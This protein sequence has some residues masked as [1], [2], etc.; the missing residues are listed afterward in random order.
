MFFYRLGITLFCLVLMCSAGVNASGI[1]ISLDPLSSAEQEWLKQHRPVSIGFDANFPPYS[2]IGE[3]GQLS[4]FAVDVLDLLE[5]RSGLRFERRIYQDWSSLYE[6]A[7]SHKIDTVATMV[8]RPER[9][10]WFRFSHPYIHKSLVIIGNSKRNDIRFRDDIDGKSIALVKGYQYESQILNE[11][12]GVK[13][14]RVDTMLDALNSVSVGQADAAITFLGAGHFYRSKYLMNDLAYLA[15]YDKNSANESYAVRADWPELAGLIDKVLASIT[16]AEMQALRKRWLPV[17]YMENLVEIEFTEAER[18]WLQKHDRVRVGIDPEFAPF[19]YLENGQYSGMASDYLELLSQR[20]NLRMEVVEGLSWAEVIDSAKQGKIDVL[21]AVGL[22]QERL[23]YLNYTDP[24]LRFHR[25]IVTREQ[26]PFIAGLND[27]RSLRVAVQANSSHQGYLQENSDIKPIVYPSLQASLMAVS[28]GEVDAFVGNVASS[29]YWIRKLNLNNLKIAAPVSNDMQSL[30]FAVSKQSPE[31]VSILQ[32]GLDS[33]GPHQRKLISEKWLSVE[34]EVERD[35]RLL[36][37]IIVGFSIALLLVLLW[38]YLLKRKVQQRTSELSYAANYDHLTGLANR[39][40]IL[41]RL[42]QW[43]IQADR[44]NTKIA[45]LSIDIDDFKKINDALGHS[46]GDLILKE[47]SERLR[48]V[49]GDEQSIGRVGGDQFLVVQRGVR[50]AADSARLAEQLIVANKRAFGRERNSVSLRSSMGIAL[51]PS[52][53]R[54]A[55]SLLKQ[56]DTATHHAKEKLPG[57][58]TFFTGQLIEKVSRKLELERHI[59]QA[60][61][62]GEFEVFFQPK[63]ETRSREIVSFEAL[64]RWNC[65]ALGAVSPVEFIPL[66]EQTG[67]IESIGYFVLDKAMQALADWKQQFGKPYSMAVNLSPLQFQ[68]DDLVPSI[69]SLLLR[70]GVSATELEFEITEGVLLSEYPGVE[71]KLNALERLGAKLAMDDFGKGYSSLSYLRK[72]RFDTLK[73]DREFISDLSLELADRKLVAATIVMAHELGL[74]VVAEGVE[75]QAQCDIL[76]HQGCDLLQGWLFS[77]AL[78]FDGITKLLT[79]Q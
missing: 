19:E 60:L 75:T 2:F 77:K 37:Y 25:V 57:R 64:L 6:D 49:V 48:T 24:Y 31:L 30:H 58:Y 39:F 8:N 67:L 73:I 38:N 69:E 68:A 34:Y 21:P 72:Y 76:A 20:L 40:L 11:F 7:K 51:F 32:K 14:V 35:Y 4:G 47:F 15:V 28:G 61:D 53:S 55:E 44:E 46:Q 33:I 54:T 71:D 63:V 3:D 70:H 16:E 17:E 29:T 52:D 43:L 36:I 27:I 12:P 18:L 79:R 65:P 23:E 1:S 56:A 62:N 50:D 26:S 9:M 13:P 45:I 78:S 5:R 42:G 66:A 59:L 41:D 22:T 74:K 10:Q